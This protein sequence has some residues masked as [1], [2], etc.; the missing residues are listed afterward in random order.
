MLPTTRRIPLRN[1]IEI[2]TPLLIPSLSS[3]AIGPLPIQS[4][5][6]GEHSL[7]A[8]SIIHSKSLVFG[9][10]ES[11]LVSA[12]DIHYGLLEDSEA[13][14]AE[15]SNSRYAGPRILL[16]DSGW[17]ERGGSSTDKQFGD[18]QYAALPWEEPEYQNTIDNLATDIRP[19]VV[20]WDHFGTYP[21]QI[22]AGQDFFGNRT[23][24]ASTLLLKPP[25]GAGVHNFDKF[26]GEDFAN[27]RAFDVIGI[28]E[29]EIGQTVMDRLENIARLRR[30]LDEKGVKSP[31]HI[32]GGLDPLYTPLYFAA[33]GEL[34]DGLGWLR[35]TYRGGVA[36]NRDAAAILD[37]QTTTS[38]NTNWISVCL[39]N[40]K[41]IGKLSQDLRLLA[42]QNLNWNLLSHGDKL[43]PIFGALQERLGA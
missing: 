2:S 5:S 22:A 11:L 24:L 43:E 31:I 16:I 3:R 9:I 35:Y 38:R 1:G 6:Y 42:H 36:M 12:Y 33:G 29:R 39:E 30:S 7:V 26:T 37:R 15:F 13:F 20:S 8:C 32:F 41:E 17:Y 23:T 21:E 25:E 28:T 40:L 18:N 10:E 34:F 14:S 27:L 4:S 19:V